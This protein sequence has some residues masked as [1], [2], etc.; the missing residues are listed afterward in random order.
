MLKEKKEERRIVDDCII[1]L[2]VLNIPP[3]LPLCGT[4][5]SKGEL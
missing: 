4:G 5:S 2:Y 3:S 1:A